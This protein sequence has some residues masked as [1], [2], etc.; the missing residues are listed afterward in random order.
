[1]PWAVLLLISY[2]G[3]VVLSIVHVNCCLSQ[4]NSLLV[5]CVTCMG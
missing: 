5:V 2:W 4:M 1:M 3:R